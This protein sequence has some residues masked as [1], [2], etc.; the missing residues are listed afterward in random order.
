[1][2][3]YSAHKISKDNFTF[4]PI[5]YSRFK[6]GSKSIARKFGK[7][8]ANRF[9]KSKEF[10]DLVSNNKEIQ[11]VVYSSPYLNIPTATFAMKDYFVADVNLVLAQY[12]CKPMQEGKIYRTLSYNEDYGAMDKDE[13]EKAISGDDFYI[14]SNF[15]KGKFAIFLDDIKITGAHERRVLSMIEKFDFDLDYIMVYY[16]ELVDET[17]H[18]NLENYLNYNFVKNLLNIDWI[19][20]NDQFIFNTRV[21]KYILNA[22]HD[23]F[24]PFIQYQSDTFRDTLLK[25]AISN[26]YHKIEGFSE[27]LTYLAQTY[28]V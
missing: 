28:V 7:D 11:I 2:R 4:D 1:M 27:N 23:E 10:F 24:K 19:I 15:L 6:Y 5:E 17:V 18:P 12:G 25:E 16:A 21:V 8:L 22:P 26:S 20:K 3:T 9:V 14:D 13:R